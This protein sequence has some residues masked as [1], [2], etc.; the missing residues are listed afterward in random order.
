MHPELVDYLRTM[1]TPG[2]EQGVEGVFVH[3]DASYDW[4]EHEDSSV[5]GI[6]LEDVSAVAEAY[7]V[8]KP[9][10][11]LMLVA[12][13]DERT[14]HT[15]ACAAEDIGFE[16]R[17]AICL[18]EA[19]DGDALHYVPKAARSE[20]EEGCSHLTGKAGH[21]AVER[22]EGSAG[23]NNPRAGAGRTAKRVKNHHPT[24]KPV[25]VMV[26]LLRDVPKDVGPVVDPFMGAGTTGVACLDE[27]T[28]HDFIGIER[29]EEYL[30]H[31]GDRV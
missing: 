22:E 2:P 15:G 25:G 31:C 11:H 10:G 23:V 5:H 16:V 9:G 30:E 17:D 29:E 26:R 3:A 13:D 14:G 18:P 21:E 19:G 6:V 28:G 4:S 12:P 1:I 7:R 24:V 20:R 8:M 27:H